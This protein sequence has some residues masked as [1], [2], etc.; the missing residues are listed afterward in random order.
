MPILLTLKLEIMKKLT[1]ILASVF[2]ISTAVS[3]H[4]FGYMSVN[5]YADAFVFDEMGVTFS[6]YPDG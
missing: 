4:E 2:T 1:L 3:A 6:V 5:S